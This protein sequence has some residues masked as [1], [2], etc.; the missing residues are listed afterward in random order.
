M[1]DI[2]VVGSSFLNVLD[3]LAFEVIPE[4]SNITVGNISKQ[5][6]IYTKGNVTINMHIHALSQGSVVIPCSAALQEKV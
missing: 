5:Q 3:R 2:A 1:A 6:S 4:R